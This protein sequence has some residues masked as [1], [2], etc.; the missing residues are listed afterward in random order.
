MPKEAFLINPPKKI[1]RKK[2]RKKKRFLRSLG[3]KFRNPIGEEVMLVGANPRRRRA[4]GRKKKYRRN[5]V[6]ATNRRRVYRR[7]NRRRYR[8][9]PALSGA[10]NITKPQT[11]LMPIAVGIGAKLAVER[12]PGMIRI[13]SPLPKLGVQAAIAIGGGILLKKP[14]GATNAAIWTV[15]ASVFA[16]SSFLNTYFKVSLR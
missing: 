1:R 16:L 11:L 10:I 12:V 7:R 13:L 9:N 14:L 15:V 4:R 5:K 2:S 8:R 3:L 6:I